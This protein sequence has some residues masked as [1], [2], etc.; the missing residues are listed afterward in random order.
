MDSSSHLSLSRHARA[1]QIH[2]STYE[3]RTDILHPP[4]EPAPI[5][6]VKNSHP[7]KPATFFLS[8]ERKVDR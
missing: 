5:N 4:G 6:H 2:S 3:S 8:L 7:I 1:D